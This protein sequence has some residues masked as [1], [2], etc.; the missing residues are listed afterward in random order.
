MHEKRLCETVQKLA[1]AACELRVAFV[2]SVLVCVETSLTS[3]DLRLSN[4]TLDG[5]VNIVDLLLLDGGCDWESSQRSI[6]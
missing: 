5:I 6:G 1:S 3:V 4:H 2:P